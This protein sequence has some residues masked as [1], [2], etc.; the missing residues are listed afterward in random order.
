MTLPKPALKLSGLVCLFFLAAAER[1]EGRF[2]PEDHSRRLL[3]AFTTNTEWFQVVNKLARHSQELNCSFV[4]P[5]GILVSKTVPSSR[6]PVYQQ[7]T[8]SPFFGK[9][10]LSPFFSTD[11]VYLGGP[12]EK[13]EQRKCVSVHGHKWK[14]NCQQWQHRQKST[15]W[16]CTSST[17][18]LTSLGFS[19]ILTA[20]TC[21]VTSSIG[22]VP[23]N[24]CKWHKEKEINI[25][26]S[27][28]CLKKWYCNYDIIH[29]YYR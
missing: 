29:D 20:L 8:V 28:I 6:E 12:C 27:T 14:I 13:Q 23:L 15:S 9:F 18:S 19:S 21:S 10:T 25:Q 11:L 5:A 17:T 26:G 24:R 4:I 2:K 22:S 1:E 3:L 7:L 16:S